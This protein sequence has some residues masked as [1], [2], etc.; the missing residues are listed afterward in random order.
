MGL[1]KKYLKSGE[2]CKVTFSLPKEAAQR[3]S[4]VNLVGDF[5]NWDYY[6]NPM[7]PLKKGDYKLDLKLESGKEYRFK[8]IIDDDQWENDWSAD[9][10]VK[11]EYGSDDSVV[12]V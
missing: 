8:Y 6:A 3:A 2:F 1:Q 4:S 12:I 9:K 5:N 11:N 7:K 10:Y